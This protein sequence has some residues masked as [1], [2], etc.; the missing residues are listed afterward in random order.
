MSQQ[1]NHTRRARLDLNLPSELAIR[2]AILEVEKLGAGVTLTNATMLLMKAKDLV[3]D[4]ID[5]NQA[6]KTTSIEQM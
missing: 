4:Y 1:R 2:E 5:N 3:S 6:G